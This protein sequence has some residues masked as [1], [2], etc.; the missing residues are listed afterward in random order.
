MK[1]VREILQKKGHQIWTIS[2]EASVFEALK[3][4]A[5]K[6]IGAL[7]VMDKND[8]AGIISERDYARKVVL[9]GRNSKDSKVKEIMS[10]K[11]IYVE[12]DRML[13][14][15]MALMIEKRIR[16]LPVYEND[17]LTGMI[18]IGDVVKAVID[19]K[20][21]VIDQLVQYIKNTPAIIRGKDRIKDKR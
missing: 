10:E 1:I 9:E 15:C 11:V 2:S 3:L 8:V 13:D 4:M 19:E 20:E 14:E 5:E 17:R 6:N 7:L 21:F 18:S 16:H 12:S